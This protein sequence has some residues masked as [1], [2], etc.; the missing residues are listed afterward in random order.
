MYTNIYVCIIT[1]IHV[2]WNKALILLTASSR[3]KCWMVACK[4]RRNDR[5]RKI[6]I[7][8]LPKL[9]LIQISSMDDKNHWVK[10]KDYSHILK[11]QLHILFISYQGGKCIFTMKMSERHCS[12]KASNLLYDGMNDTMY[13]PPLWL[14][15][16]Q[17]CPTIYVVPRIFLSYFFA[18]YTNI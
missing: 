18:V 5:I 6:T 8:Q 4:C 13:L 12:A 10:R 7:L 11:L 1:H 9:K 3:K 15:H 2:Y 16:W 17:I 14:I